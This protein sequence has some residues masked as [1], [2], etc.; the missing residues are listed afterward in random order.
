MTAPN[1]KFERLR[2]VE[3]IKD[4]LA[5]CEMFTKEAVFSL[6]AGDPITDAAIGA[7]LG[8]TGSVL[9]AAWGGPSTSNADDFR[10]QSWSR[11]RRREERPTGDKKPY[12]MDSIIAVYTKIVAGSVRSTVS[13]SSY[14][15]TTK[16]VREDFGIHL[17]Y[18]RRGM[19]GYIKW[20]TWGVSKIQNDP[21]SP[22][23]GET[24][25]FTVNMPATVTGS[26]PNQYQVSQ[27]TNAFAA[28]TPTTTAVTL[29]ANVS[30]R[31]ESLEWQ[32]GRVLVKTVWRA[33]VP[34][35]VTT[36]G[37]TTFLMKPRQEIG[38]KFQVRGLEIPSTVEWTCR[39]TSSVETD[40]RAAYAPGSSMPT[41]GGSANVQGQVLLGYD[42]VCNTWSGE[43]EITAHYG[44]YIG[45]SGLIGAGY[46]LP[47][48]K[49]RQDFALKVTSGPDSEQLVGKDFFD[50]S[51]NE[52]Q[53]QLNG[54]E[55]IQGWRLD[56]DMNPMTAALRT[57]LTNIWGNVDSDSGATSG[58]LCLEEDPQM[59][60][61]QTRV[62]IDFAQVASG[63]SVAQKM[64]W[65]GGK[66]VS[67]G[68]D[69]VN[70]GFVA[71]TTNFGNGSGSGGLYTYIVALP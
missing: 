14:V 25:T 67:S 62:R 42:I 71:P 54:A 48:S 57:V 59:N 40:F 69:P 64:I 7:F 49:V 46:L 37:S 31:T 50:G 12:A 39:H 3:S 2:A 19:E 30:E 28:G 60:H 10:L 20:T 8:G 4:S 51:G 27:P 43:D 17:G 23:I 68:D 65:Q 13:G 36:Q 34:M 45:D 18:W 66:Y 32:M 5:E 63:S 33:W 41:N 24:R 55:R 70:V 1:I 53:Y 58:W 29:T 11:E 22:Q 56:F 35:A 16:Q 21:G 15:E 38:Y 52:C 44:K 47:Y 6:Q 9:P 61:G 26:S